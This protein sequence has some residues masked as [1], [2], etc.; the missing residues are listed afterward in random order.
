MSEHEHEHE[1]YDADSADLAEGGDLVPEATMPLGTGAF[2]AEEGDLALLAGSGK[3]RRTGPLV[4]IGVVVLAV[5]GLVCMHALSKITAAARGDT[6]IEQTIDLFLT[7]VTKS[8]AGGSSQSAGELVRS[9]RAV[10][11][12]LSDDYTA[13]QV[14]LVDVQFNPFVIQRDSRSGY[15]AVPDSGDDESRRLERSR[16][17]RRDEIESAC[18]KLHLKSVIMGKVTLANLSGRIVRV[19]E[20]VPIKTDG[21]EF[22]VT[23]ITRDSITLTATEPSLKLT[24]DVVVELNRD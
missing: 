23:S 17:K 9:H 4:L 21:I 6:A 11:D 19:G 3:R 22:R 16:A 10:V 18:R 24:V 13:L 1:Q 15:Q 7:S 5:G 2:A 8:Q 12:I 14:P 20:V